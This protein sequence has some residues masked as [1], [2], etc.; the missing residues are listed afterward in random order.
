MYSEITTAVDIYKQND[1]VCR[2]C[3]GLDHGGKAKRLKLCPARN[4]NCD[5]C[6]IRGH[7]SN[8]GAV[9]FG[10]QFGEI[11]ALQEGESRHSVAPS[12]SR[13]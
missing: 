13:N 6:N 8:A 12:S 10:P 5:K 7:Y 2:G 3:D 4:A 11:Q 9:R 1:M